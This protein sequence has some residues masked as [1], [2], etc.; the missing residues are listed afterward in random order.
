MNYL[1]YELKFI[2]QVRPPDSGTP[3]KKALA[4]NQRLLQTKLL[5]KQNYHIFN[6]TIQTN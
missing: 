1:V 4:K 5:H 3:Q 6:L 2:D